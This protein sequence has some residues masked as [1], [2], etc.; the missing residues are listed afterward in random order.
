MDL[1]R[2]C[3]RAGVTGFVDRLNARLL[4]ARQSAN[5]TASRLT[6]DIAGIE[7]L[8]ATT[9]DRFVGSDFF[10]VAELRDG[11]VMVADEHD[12]DWSVLLNALDRSGRCAYPSA[13]WMLRLLA[14]EGRT[15]I[16][17]IEPAPKESA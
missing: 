17:L 9:A 5:R 1:A 4:H 15:P 13:Q 16:V 6:A 11:S 2:A 8:V 7:R 14:D 12:P 10:L 3:W